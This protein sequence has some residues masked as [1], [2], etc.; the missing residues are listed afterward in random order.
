MTDDI[1]TWLRELANDWDLLRELANDWDY[2][3]LMPKDDLRVAA[4][5]IERLRAAGD[6]LAECLRFWADFNDEGYPDRDALETW[7]EARRG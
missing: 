1:V 4:D 5:E 7:E 6:E 2:V 3:G